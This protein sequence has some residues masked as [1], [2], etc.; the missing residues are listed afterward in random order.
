VTENLVARGLEVFYVAPK[1]T[2]RK[3]LDLHVSGFM[4]T[5][6]HD[7]QLENSWLLLRYIRENQIDAAI[8]ND[9]PVLQSI[10][11]WLDIPLLVIGHMEKFAIGPVACHASEWVDYVVAISYDMRKSFIRMGVQPHQC[12]VVYNGVRDSGPVQHQYAKDRALRVAY[13]GDT[14]RKGM[15]LVWLSLRMGADA[16][17]GLELSWYG[18]IPERLKRALAAEPASFLRIEGKLPRDDF[19]R[20]LKEADVLLLPSRAE[21]CPMALLEAMSRGVV[22]IV[23]DGLGA[24]SWMVDSGVDGFVCSL[25]NWP[26]ESLACLKILRDDPELLAALSLK[27]R[28]RFLRQFDIEFTVDK[29]LWLLSHPV[30]QRAVKPKSIKVL[31]W[32]R[33][34]PRAGGTKPSL[35]ERLCFRLGIK[36][37]DG[38][39]SW[40]DANVE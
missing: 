7:D 8:N 10:A 14:K 15:D 31:H 28:E 25:R 21:G 11:P 13:A 1:P 22:P 32:H 24:M 16:W 20:A 30:V 12:P 18:R 2:N 6:E 34:G 19:E 39:L 23:S 4:S 40:G 27:T 3:W 36:R 5:D 35:W 17:E 29:L 9:N 37:F 26:T 33:P 38:S